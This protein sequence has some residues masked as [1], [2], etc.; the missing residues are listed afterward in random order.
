MDSTK[1]DSF[2]I[3]AK[4]LLLEQRIPFDQ[5]VDILFGIF[6]IIDEASIMKDVWRINIDRSI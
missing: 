4:I 6:L 1:S 2:A 5:A 3:A